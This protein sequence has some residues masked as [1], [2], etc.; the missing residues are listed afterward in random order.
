MFVLV[1]YD[2]EGKRTN[3]FR[4]LLKRYL[5]HS[6]FSVFSG[7]LSESKWLALRAELEAVVEIGDK[8]TELVTEN[9]HNVKVTHFV[10]NAANRGRVTK[11]KSRKHCSD[12]DVF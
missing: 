6:Q 7:D 10:K 12:F 3:I 2:V 9:R 5:D 8:I 11:E 4:K 1:M